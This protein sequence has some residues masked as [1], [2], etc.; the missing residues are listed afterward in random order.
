VNKTEIKNFVVNKQKSAE[1]NMRKFTD[2]MND[3]KNQFEG[4]PY[5]RDYDGLAETFPPETFKAI[6]T[7]LS[8]E[9]YYIFGEEFFDIKKEVTS[10]PKKCE[11]YKN[12]M[13]EQFEDAGLEGQME[14][15][16][17]SA[18]KNGSAIAK[19]YWED[20]IKEVY[21]KEINETGQAVKVRKIESK[22]HT[23]FKNLYWKNVFILGDTVT[24][25]KIDGVIERIENVDWEDLWSRRI[26]KET[27]ENG[28]KVDRGVYFDLDKAEIEN[29]LPAT[30]VLEDE[31]SLRYIT[32]IESTSKERKTKTSKHTLLEMWTYYDLD[33]DGKKEKVV[34]TVLDEKKLI[35]AGRVPFDHNEFPYLFHSYFKKD[36][37]LFGIGVCGLTE[38]SQSELNAKHNQ[39]LDYVTFSLNNMWTR[40]DPNIPDSHLTSRPNGI[41]DVA[42]HDDIKPLYPP[43]I[44]LSAAL[45]SEEMLRD[46]I[47]TPPG[48]TKSLQGVQLEGAATA[49]EV[50]SLVAEGNYRVVLI[51]KALE[52]EV[53]EPLVYMSHA[54]NTQYQEEEVK[55]ATTVEG[56]KEE[57][58]TLEQKD[59]IYPYKFRVKVA[60]SVE[61]KVVKNQMLQN[62]MQILM[63]SGLPPQMTMPAVVKIVKKIWG[64]LGLSIG[65]EIISDDVEQSFVQQLQGMGQPGMVPGGIP[66]DPT[67]SGIPQGVPQGQPSEQ[68]LLQNLLRGVPNEQ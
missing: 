52:R 68:A 25:D 37:D 54:N 50:R 7:L 59:I 24:F 28:T 34:L 35:R 8:R 19:V 17:L 65:E 22:G 45:Q 57:V 60:A 36:D 66:V 21:K 6:E 2:K 10:D 29:I 48:S 12:Y 40:T 43:Q 18:K 53:L 61:N 11:A 33:G 31:K 49:T 14:R 44:N 32:P 15:F 47:A 38:R 64:N 27:L 56:D 3:W 26:R 46:D 63:G 20:E 13:L 62:F 9:M 41:I 39:L 4:V 67:Q 55:V 58:V 16:L 5:R 42:N 1:T 30:T 23:V 51:A